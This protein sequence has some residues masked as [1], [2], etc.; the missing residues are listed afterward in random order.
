MK[1]IAKIAGSLGLLLLFGFAHAA[2]AATLSVSP[3]A[4]TVNVGDTFTVDVLLD[5][6]G[7]PI[8]GVDIKSLNY[9]PYYM[10]LVD[11]DAATDGTQIAA[12]TLMPST[13]ANSA[14]TVN[15]KVVFSQITNAGTNY[16]GSGKLATLTFKAITAGPSNLT[17]DFV[18][19][20]TT[21]SNVASQGNDIL[22]SV[23]NGQ[24]IINNTLTTVVGTSPSSTPV[25]SS[26]SMRLVNI[27]G[28]YYL[29]IDGVRHGIT[30]P[31][32]LNSY[33]FR[34]ADAVAATAADIAL[35]EGSLLLP[36]EGALVKS[37]QDQTVYL[38][39]GQQRYGFTSATVFTSL[40]F[41]FASVLVVTNPELQA[42]AKADALL[43]DGK[44]RHLPGLDINRNGTVYWIGYDSQL[45]GY[46]DLAAYNSWHIK[47]DFTRVVPANAADMNLPQGGLVGARILN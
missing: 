13:L 40:G 19:G 33:G 15:G 18:Q 29:I 37:V 41:K 20:A 2:S 44:A 34:L 26:G 27:N 22:S 31:G 43:N 46:P 10:Q 38:I 24:Y 42:L 5:T 7:Q 16:T 8:D 4:K 39:S 36:G 3:S 17:F 45:H 6:Q 9:N 14:D 32:M 28:T 47:N 35:P 25:V 11:A 1:L 12:G 23:T 30:N 21:D